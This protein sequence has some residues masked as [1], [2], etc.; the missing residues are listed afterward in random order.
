[1]EHK[2]PIPKFLS[3]RAG[4]AEEAK[5]SEGGESFNADMHGMNTK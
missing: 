3:A 4:G 2:V 5:V 1:M